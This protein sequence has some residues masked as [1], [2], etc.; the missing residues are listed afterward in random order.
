MSE[1]RE[2]N[3][4]VRGKYNIR[5]ILNAGP[6]K[7]L[8]IDEIKDDQMVAA[9]AIDAYTVILQNCKSIRVFDCINDTIKAPEIV[10]RHCEY[11]E[12]P[13]SIVTTVMTV[14]DSVIHANSESKILRIDGDLVCTK[15]LFEGFDELRVNGTVYLDAF[16]KAHLGDRLTKVKRTI[17][18]GEIEEISPVIDSRAA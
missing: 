4:I 16:T 9:A 18:L 2:K 7:T 13:G 8:S 14:Q 5:A 1:E 12:L 6:V 11:V 3:L 17:D 15:S 10:I